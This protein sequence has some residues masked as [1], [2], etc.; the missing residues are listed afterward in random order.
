MIYPDGTVLWVT[1]VTYKVRCKVN[2]GGGL[3]EAE[4]E[5]KV[6]F[7]SWTEGDQI[8][9]VPNNYSPTEKTGES[10]PIR[11]SEYYLADQIEIVSKNLTL[12]EKTYNCCPDDDYTHLELDL[13]LRLKELP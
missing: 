11:I 9:I 7:G 2:M 6:V 1:P 8:Q 3:V 5:C 10:G 13:K 4:Q 12:V